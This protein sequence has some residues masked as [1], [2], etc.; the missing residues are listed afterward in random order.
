MVK[1]AGSEPWPMEPFGAPLAGLRERTAFAC[2]KSAA[3]EAQTTGDLPGE[4]FGR[5]V[6]AFG[7]PSGRGGRPG[8]HIHRHTVVDAFRDVF[9]KRADRPPGVA[10]LQAE[11]DTPCAAHMK[12]RS[13]WSWRGERETALAR[14]AQHRP[15]SA[16]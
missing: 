5:V 1:R 2:K 3:W 15:G 8:H 12:Q 9:R 6:S 16:T 14:T 11:D 7:N 4:Q 13:G 10:V